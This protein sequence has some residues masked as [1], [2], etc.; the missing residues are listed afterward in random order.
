[1]KLFQALKTQQGKTSKRN[2]REEYLK[3]WKSGG[4]REK[5]HGKFKSINS[6][7]NDYIKDWNLKKWKCE[8]FQSM[9]ARERIE[10]LKVRW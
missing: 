9:E 8:R 7:I 1:M 6:E 10:N 2:K 3:R 4:T 5:R